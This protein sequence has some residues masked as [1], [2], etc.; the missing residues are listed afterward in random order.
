MLTRHISCNGHIESSAHRINCSPSGGCTAIAIPD[1]NRVG[2]FA[3]SAKRCARLECTIV[4]RVG[5]VCAR[6]TSNGYTSIR[7]DAIGIGNNGKNWGVRDWVNQNILCRGGGAIVVIRDRD[8]I[9]PCSGHINGTGRFARIP[10]VGTAF[11]S[12]KHHGLSL[13]RHIITRNAD[14][15]QFVDSD[16]C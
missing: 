7:I 1:R 6:R 16:L 11:R 10:S 8:G 3:Q 15:G 13:T 12:G 9:G 14:F 2:A 5:V 4:E